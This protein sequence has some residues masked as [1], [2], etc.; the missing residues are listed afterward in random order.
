MFARNSMNS[1]NTHST[2]MGCKFLL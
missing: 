1:L 2:W